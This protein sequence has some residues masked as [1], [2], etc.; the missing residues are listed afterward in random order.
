M[1]SS[2]IS[3]KSWLFRLFI[4]FVDCLFAVTAIYNGYNVLFIQ[5]FKS[6]PFIFGLLSLMMTIVGLLFC[7]IYPFIWQRKEQMG[8]INSEK[9]RSWIG[10]IVR[11][12]LAASICTYGFAKILKTQFEQSVST[13][14]SLVRSLSGFDLTWNYFGHSYAL[15]VIIAIFQIGGSVLLLFRR[16]TL[17]GAV[18][19][20]P[21]MLNILLINWFYHIGAYPFLNSI[22]YILGLVYL[23][24]FRWK[25]IKAILFKPD[26]TFPVIHLGFVKFLLRIFVVVYPLGLIYHLAYTDKTPF[27]VGKWQV[28]Q[29]IRNND[30]L[31]SNAWLTD[32]TAWKNIYIEENG[33]VFIS[34]NPY[35]L[36]KRKSYRGTYIYDSAFDDIVLLFGRNIRQ[37]DTMVVK[38]NVLNSRQMK[39]DLVSHNDSLLLQLSKVESKNKEN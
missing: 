36:D 21:V 1:Q 10:G 29:M 32:S 19:L 12:W 6:L 16:T 31:Q 33:V 13:N 3:E 34:S 20:F 8:K 4:K 38:V 30:T 5:P 22:L 28:D 11:Y 25:D 15:A 39:W 18:I 14:D 2:P 17:L 35:M 7:I 9:L 23:L 26:Y 24:L 27:L 37:Q